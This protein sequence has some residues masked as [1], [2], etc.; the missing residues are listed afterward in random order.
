VKT[1][2][3]I[4]NNIVA[5]IHGLLWTKRQDPRSGDSGSPWGSAE[6][7]NEPF[8]PEKDELSEEAGCGVMVIMKSVDVRK[9]VPRGKWLHQK[10]SFFQPVTPEKLFRA[11]ALLPFL[12][13]FRDLDRSASG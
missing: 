11:Q 10:I 12:L 1:S 4:I 3:L 2:Q 5:G 9:S 7:K 6:L 8:T 13:D